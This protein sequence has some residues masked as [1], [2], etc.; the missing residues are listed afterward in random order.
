MNTRKD[1]HDAAVR[2]IAQSLIEKGYSVTVEPDVAEIPFSL[3]GYKPDILAQKSDDNLIIEIKGPSDR[4]H[5]EKYQNIASIISKNPGWRFLISTISE[6]LDEV[7]ISAPLEPIDYSSIF[8]SLT[9]IDSLLSSGMHIYAI[10]FLWNTLITTLRL[11]AQNS[12]IAVDATSDLRVLNYMY[13]L[14]VLS[15]EDYERCRIYLKL[16]NE[17]VHKINFTITRDQA[18]EMRRFVE[19]QIKNL[20]NDDS[21]EPIE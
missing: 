6:E 11:H 10:P 7:P 16:R 20:K 18:D 13:S 1:I 8:E 21:A 4:S 3:N 9:R 15:P 12:G 14:G 5:V 17:A 2:R 19:L